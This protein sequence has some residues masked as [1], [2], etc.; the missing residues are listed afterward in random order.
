M[1][2]C[3]TTSFFRRILNFR[4]VVKIGSRAAQ[5]NPMYADHYGIAMVPGI[6]K[7]YLRLCK[8]YRP[9]LG[10]DSNRMPYHEADEGTVELK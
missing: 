7:A 6:G 2:A 4:T 8:E 5:C 9:T 10:R 1:P 3:D